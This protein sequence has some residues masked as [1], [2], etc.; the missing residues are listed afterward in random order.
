MNVIQYDG[1]ADIAPITGFSLRKTFTCGQC[2]RFDEEGDGYSGVAFGRYVRFA[3]PAP[4]ILRIYGE[5]ASDADLWIKYLAL[6]VDYEAIRL[7]IA[8]RFDCEIMDRALEYGE[9]I[10]ILRQQPWEVICSFIISQ[11]NNI[12]RIKKII[13]ALSRALGEPAAGSDRHHAFPT[14]EALFKLGTEGIFALGTGFRAKYIYDA[15]NRITEGIIDLNALAAQDTRTLIK[16][17][18]TVKGIGLKV[19]SCAALFGFGR[20]EVF[21]VDVWVRR[22]ID[23]HFGG[24]LDIDSLGE[25]AGIAQQ[26]LFYYERENGGRT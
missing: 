4:D 11:N 1:Y 3:Q 16:E 5:A 24:K 9:G 12:G 19:A 21:P 22:S 23:R 26:Y 10:R 7:D 25:Y 13:A 6:D 20:T 17:L 14:P 2:F 15:A 8:R 18:C